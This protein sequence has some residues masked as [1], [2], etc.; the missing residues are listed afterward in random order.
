MKTNNSKFKIPTA[1]MQIG[2]L[3]TALLLI[4][5]LSFAAGR[6]YISLS[7]LLTYFFTGEYSNK[8][9][10]LLVWDIRLPR[11]L[12]AILAGG[13]LSV[14][15]AA[16]QG[17]FRNPVVSPDILGV[18][19]GAGF[20]AAFA[21]M[22]SAGLTVIQVSAFTVG[23]TAVTASLLISQ[24][25]D[26][27][28]NR[29]L[30]LVLSGMIVGS[31]FGAMTMMLKY[32]AD[33]QSKLPEITFWLMGGF[34]NVTLAEIKFVAPVITLSLIPLFLNSWKINI[35]SFGDEEAQTL[36][37]NT[38]RL[39]FI[40]IVCA[41]LLT[42]SV[43]SVTG[44][45]GWVGLIV[46]HFTRFI[47]GADHRRLLPASFL[48]GGAFLLLVDDIVRSVSSLEIP[49]GVITS[50]VGAP[51]FLIVLRVFGKGR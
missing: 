43:V 42:A 5:V 23:I 6:Y 20:G 25:T 27:I 22:F 39:R 32:L 17:L 41:S 47:V 21:I 19:S 49:L 31:L 18:S 45:I 9:L 15:G 46:P 34:T 12:I 26:M 36:G 7:D 3:A 38:G 1:G 51:I 33:S 14:S 8:N 16:Y 11:I 28:H 4:T 2:M 30:M 13:A 44:I 24:S 48:V 40:I 10:P 29:I 37:I 50:I 35:L